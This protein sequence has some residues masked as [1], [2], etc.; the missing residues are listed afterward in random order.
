MD[1]VVQEL[2]DVRVAPEDRQRALIDADDVEDQQREQRSGDEP[3][4][5]SAS[6]G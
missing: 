3:R 1:P 4:A 2:V 5:T 6:E